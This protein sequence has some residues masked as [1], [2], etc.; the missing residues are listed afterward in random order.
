MME[1]LL[2]LLIVPSEFLAS[3]IAWFDAR[4]KATLMVILM[5]ILFGFT[6][7]RLAFSHRRFT[8]G[9]ISA[10]K[11]VQRATA[12]R[13][14][15]HADRLNAAAK[16]IEANDVLSDAWRHYRANLREAPS[17]SGSF[18]NLVDP[19]MWFT[20]DRLR[21]RGYEK[22]ATTW[23][24]VFLTI[25][26]FFTFVGLSAALIQ[27]GTA[28][29]SD[30]QLRTMINQILKISSAK[31]ITS[32]MGIVFFIAWTII[33]RRMLSGQ[34]AVC[35]QFAREVQQLTTMIAPEAI[36]LDQLEASRETTKR[37][38]TLADDVAVAFDAKLTQVVGTRLDL[39]PEK[40]DD[41]IQPVVAAITNMSTS[42]GSGTQS[43]IEGTVEL[44]LKEMREAIGTEMKGVAAALKAAADELQKAQ[45]GIGQTGSQFGSEIM[46]ATEAMTASVMRM[47]HTLE[48]SLGGLQAKINNVD[49]ALSRGASTIGDVSTQ[50]SVGIKSTLE[51]ALRKVSEQATIAAEAARQQSQ[52]QLR[53][54]FEE[55]RDLMGQLK[56]GA[57]LGRGKL[58]EGSSSAAAQIIDAA[59]VLGSSLTNASNEASGRL[60]DAAGSIAARIDAAAAQF[61]AIE[62]S[63][64]ANVVHLERTGT[65]I[66]AA[67]NAF[68]AAGDKLRQA[69]DPI[70]STLI[71]VE[72]AA[73]QA[74][75]ALRMAG[76]ADESLRAAA[77]ALTETSEKAASAFTDYRQRFS[78][79]DTALGDAFDS[80]TSGV[81]TLSKEV[82]EVLAK[83]DGHL[84]KGLG[85]LGGG[86]DQVKEMVENMAT[87]VIDLADVIGRPSAR[88]E[89]V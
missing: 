12:Q 29:Q 66:A 34:V 15:T 87:A 32:V 80:L 44:L 38:M 40:L 43:A 13:E 75:D 59:R 84:A 67:G 86:V 76:A 8:A 74:T 4:E 81:G 24:G 35:D 61:Q 6:W 82:A 37:M 42:I 56:E 57:E 36:L 65:S 85:H 23:A 18:V 1:R 70:A 50:L 71:A 60:S 46:K 22:W 83:M 9:V 49:D 54:L 53:P 17:N 20:P 88:A 77:A 7:A 14:W 16:E 27:V 48:T 41:S 28:G 58:I 69:A 64:A 25:G 52:A 47:S 73:R 21:G 79:T 30:E 89:R 51:E 19:R 33:A 3:G 10:T 45:G 11:A 68:G 5:T 62:R 55:L 31:F 39:L 26:L 63:V 2:Q 78:D 72:A